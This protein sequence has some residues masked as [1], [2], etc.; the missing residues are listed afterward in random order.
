[1]GKAI[2]LQPR[3]RPSDFQEVEAPR[4]KDNR[5][6]K[7]VSLSAPH[8]GRLYHTGNI[9]GNHFRYGLIPP[10]CHSVAGSIMSMKNSNDTIGEFFPRRSGL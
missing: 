4:F 1:M 2:P 3:A 9:R 10:Q 5:H 6:M 7:R 8:T